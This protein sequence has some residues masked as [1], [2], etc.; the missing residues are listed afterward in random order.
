MQ[1]SHIVFKSYFVLEKFA[2]KSFKS[3]DPLF[4]AW[5]AGCL[6]NNYRFQPSHPDTRSDCM[7]V[8]LNEEKVGRIV[9]SIEIL[10]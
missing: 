4:Y 10:F 7:E 8:T 5:T 3:S 6:L 9:F 1:L 2:Q